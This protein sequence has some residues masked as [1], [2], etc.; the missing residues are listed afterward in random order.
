MDNIFDVITNKIPKPRAADAKAL[1]EISPSGQASQQ[2]QPAQAPDIA[3]MPV[4]DLVVMWQK[5]EKPEYTSELLRRMNPTITAAINSYAPN[6]GGKYD[7]KSAKL[8]LEALRAYDPKYGTEPQT[9]VF[10]NLKRLNRIAGQSTNIIKQSESR[11]LERKLLQEASVN[12]EDDHGREPSIMELSELTGLSRK[13]VEQLLDAE[14]VVVPESAT[15][16]ESLHDTVTNAEVNDDDCFEYVYASVGPIDQKI[17]EW[18]SGK[19]GKPALSN[20]Q[21]AA[22]LGVSAAAVSQRKNKIA[23]MLSDVRSLI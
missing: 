2:Q 22:K 12:F 14:T 6:S 23:Q 10:N 15:L 20:N 19:H 13:K 18:T 1:A 7:I 16:T 4:K 8:T 17:M 21:I 5:D 3:K 9:Y 11:A